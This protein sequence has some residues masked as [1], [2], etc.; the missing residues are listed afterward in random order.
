MISADKGCDSHMEWVSYW[1]CLVY[2]F[3]MMDIYLIM[4]HEYHLRISKWN[5]FET[6]YN[7]KVKKKSVKL[8]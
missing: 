4:Y 8:K 1:D 5:E 3:C 6:Y 7:N 2:K